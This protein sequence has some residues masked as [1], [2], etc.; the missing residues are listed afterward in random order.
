MSERANDIGSA[1]GEPAAPASWPEVLAEGRFQ[2]AYRLHGLGDE[3][4]PEIDAT[5][6]AL[7]EIEGLVR[8][9]GWTRALNR[10]RRL[11]DPPQLLDWVGLESDLT[12]LW[13]SSKALDRR[14]SARALE[15]LRSRS[16]VFF[17][18][19]VETQRGTALIFDD[20]LEAAKGHFERALDLDPRHHRAITNLGNIA[21]EQGRIDEA[22]EAYERAIR[23]NDDFPNAYHN[24]GV[25]YRRRGEFGK[26][27][28][29]LRR[30]QRALNRH[31]A[32]T[33]RSQLSRRTGGR[34]GLGRNVRWILIAAAVVVG[35]L[36]L[37]SRGVI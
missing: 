30:A 35:Y 14:E 9:K 11:E 24:L 6:A 2:Q 32:E 33:A 5:L 34:A 15:L 20:E 28:R 3:V 21:L 23:I 27:V 13:E 18:A 10:L 26:S 29:M 37:R 16:T 17:E 8:D 7:A 25:A 12:S 36:L 1:A 19:E 31:E 4:D 22:V